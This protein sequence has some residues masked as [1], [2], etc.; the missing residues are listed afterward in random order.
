MAQ[1]IGT[2][3]SLTSKKSGEHVH[4]LAKKTFR[5]APDGINTIVL[6]HEVPTKLPKQYAQLLVESGHGKLV[7]APKEKAEPKKKDGDGDDKEHGSEDQQLRVIE[8][9]KLNKPEMVKLAVDSDLFTEK[10]AN[11]MG[12]EALA[13]AIA[14]DELAD[15]EDDG[16]D[17]DKD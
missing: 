4:F 10:E 8:L 5:S 14:K 16:D 15:E 17:K 3:G 11:A 7:D 1:L 12:K 9:M 13:T 2:V 6:S